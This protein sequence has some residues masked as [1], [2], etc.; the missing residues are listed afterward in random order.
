VITGYGNDTIFG[1]ADANFISNRGG[2]DLWMAAR[3][4]IR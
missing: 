4:T 2:S 3:A 1:S